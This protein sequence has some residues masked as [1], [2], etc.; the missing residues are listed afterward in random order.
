MN[1]SPKDKKIDL[2]ATSMSKH[3]ITS[4]EAQMAPVAPEAWPDPTTSD[5]STHKEE[6][7]PLQQMNLKKQSAD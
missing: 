2:T 5:S 7:N 1:H 6:L 3:W 4:T